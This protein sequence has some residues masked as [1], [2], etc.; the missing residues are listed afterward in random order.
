VK[1]PLTIRLLSGTALAVLLAFLPVSAERLAPVTAAGQGSLW[2]MAWAGDAEEEGDGDGEEEDGEE[3]DGEEDDGEED[4]EGE[5]GN[6]GPGDGDS[7]DDDDDDDD[8]DEDDD[9]DDD[10]DDD[11]DDGDDDGGGG[12]GSGGS[13]ASGSG[14]QSGQA[15]DNSS[16]LWF[17]LGDGTRVEIS[18]GGRDLKLLYANGWREEIVKGRYVLRDEDNR[19][20]VDRI[21]TAEDYSRLQDYISA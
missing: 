12:S 19:L 10:D 16:I 6:S 13:G 7:G 1:D 14:G 5:G 15:G 9:D 2:A 11:H 18:A 8:E 17:Y 3:D 21:A 20:V 4:G